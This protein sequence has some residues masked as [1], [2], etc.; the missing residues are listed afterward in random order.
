[1]QL[2]VEKSV[3]L[4]LSLSHAEATNVF[5][6]FS[7]ALF[8]S[9]EP[10]DFFFQLTNTENPFFVVCIVVDVFEF[11]EFEILCGLIRFFGQLWLIL[12]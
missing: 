2:R 1:M 5:R 12:L 4:L 8:I 11:G 3:K 10:F 7:F 9:S 6:Y